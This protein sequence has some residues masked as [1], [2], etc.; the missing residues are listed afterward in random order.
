M[1]VEGIPN[2]IWDSTA[3]VKRLIREERPSAVVY[4]LPINT[5]QQVNSVNSDGEL[6]ALLSSRYDMTEIGLFWLWLEK[7]AE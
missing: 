6:Q 3:E 4:G 2:A 5:I 1:Q 7:P